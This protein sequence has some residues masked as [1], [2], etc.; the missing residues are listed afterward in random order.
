[1][2]VHSNKHSTCSHAGHQLKASHLG[3]MT[4]HVDSPLKAQF[5]VLPRFKSSIKCVSKQ[6]CFS[7]L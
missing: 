7:Y 4:T 2:G 3:G 1:M 6:E 5:P